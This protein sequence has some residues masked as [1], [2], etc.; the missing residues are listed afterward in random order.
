LIHSLVGGG[1]D[2]RLFGLVISQQ[3]RDLKRRHPK[4]QRADIL[5]KKT[6]SHDKK[7]RGPAEKLRGMR[8][9]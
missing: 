9:K 2:R 5:S 1:R 3:G 7:M 6:G 4:T 8:K